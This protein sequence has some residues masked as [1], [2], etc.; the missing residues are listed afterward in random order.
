[1]ESAVFIR[2]LTA[3]VVCT[4]VAV[5]VFYPVMMIIENRIFFNCTYEGSIKFPVC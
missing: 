1:M 3:T 4:A 2:Q 5:L